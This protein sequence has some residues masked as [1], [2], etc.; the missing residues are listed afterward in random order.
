MPGLF[1]DDITIGQ[2]FEAGPHRVD[3]D[4]ILDFANRFDPNP[5]HLDD[6]A[7]QEA[8]LPGIIAS[9]FHTLSLSF[10]LFFELHIWDDAIIPSPGLNN[11]RWL[12][13]LFPGDELRIRATILSKTPSQSRPDRGAVVALHE[14][15]VAGGEDPILTVEAIHRLR[16]RAS[17]RD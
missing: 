10:R 6:E 2:A 13:P 12:K 1:F 3:R 17:K 16:T 4:E 5:F 7:A 14:S 11:I 15:F 9:G 8:G